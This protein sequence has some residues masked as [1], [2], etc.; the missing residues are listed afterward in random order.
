MIEFSKLTRVG[1]RHENDNSTDSDL[2]SLKGIFGLTSDEKD[3]AVSLCKL[4]EVLDVS[5][6]P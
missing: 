6:S 4:R 5:E 3:H 1:C 2:P